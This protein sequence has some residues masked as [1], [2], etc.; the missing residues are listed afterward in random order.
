MNGVMI[1]NLWVRNFTLSVLPPLPGAPVFHSFGS[2][3]EMEVSFDVG[4]TW[5]SAASPSSDQMR[6]IYSGTSGGQNIYTTEM[7]TMSVSGGSLPMGVMIRESPT[8]ASNGQTTIK[9]IS[10]GYMIDSFFDIFIE[11]STDNGMTWAPAQGPTHIDLLVDPA[12][13]PAASNGPMMLP[14]IMCQDVSTA[15]VWQSYASG[16][17]LKNVKHKLWSM[18]TMPP[19]IGTSI[20]HSYS[21]IVDYEIS[22]D[23]GATFQTGRA[24]ATATETINGTR[25][26]LGAAT[27]ETEMTSLSISGGDLPIGIIIRESPTKASQGGITMTG[28]IGTYTVSSFFD[29]FTEISTDGGLSWQPAASGPGHLETQTIAHKSSYTSKLTP[30]P[31]AEF[32]SPSFKYPTGIVIKDFVA[33]YPSSSIMPPVAGSTITHSYSSEVKM[34]IST[35]SGITFTPYTSTANITMRLTGLMD[36]A[37]C[38]CFEIEIT[39]YN[40]ILPG[41]FIRESPTRASLGRLCHCIP[42]GPY[43]ISSFF[44]IFTEVSTDGGMTWASCLGG[45]GTVTQNPVVVDALT[46]TCPADMTVDATSSSGATVYYSPTVSGGYPP[47]TTICNPPSGSLLPVGATI[48]NCIAQDAI[49]NTAS[50]SFRVT[51]KPFVKRY[52]YDADKLTPANGAYICRSNSFVTFA[53][54][55]VIKNFW[56]RNFTVS[57]PPPVPGVP[58]TQNS[59]SQTSFDLS[60]D[61]GGT[62]TPVTLSSLN[63][64][65]MT[66]NTTIGG[67][68]RYDTEMLQMDL[69]GGS[70]PA[71]ILIRESPTKASQGES[72]IKP[73]TGGYMISS[74]FDIFI[75]VSTD[76]GISWM[77]STTPAQIDLIPDPLRTTA[78]ETSSQ[79]QPAPL[80]QN[81]STAAI[82][83]SYP[84]G[85]IIRNV[86][87]KLF[88][89]S[90]PGPVFGGGFTYSY[91]SQTDMQL[92]TDGGITWS[93]VRAPSQMTLMIYNVGEFK[94]NDFYDTEV[95]A[96]NISGGGLPV[97]VMIRESP[98]LISRGFTALQ[99]AG[100]GGGGGRYTISSFFD[101]FTEIST[102][103][104]LTW[105]QSGVG[106][107]HF[108]LLLPD[109]IWVYPDPVLRPLTGEYYNAGSLTATYPS[110]IQIANLI[111]SRYTSSVPVPAPGMTQ[112]ESYG[113]QEKMLISFDNG[114]TWSRVV[115][116]SSCTA[117]ITS[118]LDYGIARY[119]TTEMTALNISGGSLPAGVMIRESPTKASMGRTSVTTASGG[120]RISSFFDIFLEITFDGGMTWQPTTAGP[121]TVMLRPLS[122]N[123]CP[124]YDGL[125]VTDLKDFATLA[126]NWRWTEKPGDSA[127]RTDND[128][129]GVV[130]FK[131]LAI[132]VGKWLQNCP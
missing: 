101:I 10:G 106:P 83:Q 56:T 45:P 114:A 41:V 124:N 97:G 11:V 75:E 2:Q 9:A 60:I 50:C 70:L 35:D 13:I 27:Y 69:S 113:A 116:P 130:G 46:I 79:V 38:N 40:I 129:D 98:T 96:Y 33:K 80:S 47:V 30:T 14:P 95:L 120:Y 1:R 67:E 25:S 73:I 127:N 44:D 23:N 71:G 19:A 52:F 90:L 92:S 94:G 126:A 118:M 58:L 122:C 110:G 112:V 31:L 86:K 102:D 51:V 111:D 63:A 125:G 5:L 32:G 76:G 16:I 21:S 105:A 43:L 77:P 53:S 121:A 91:N 34:L 81:V 57:S 93:N 85:I 54:G 103:G 99:T 132:F 20:S 8:L 3:V 87:H 72:C 131:D 107:G 28:S 6:I 74:F 4:A 88:D 82:W 48:V 36:S 17:V 78:G 59:V 18:S 24:P 29:I 128:C 37:D 62:F 15:A 55:I 26:F 22:L 12:T 100:G 66:Y 117:Q 64:I 84:S 65:H 39:S 119:F 61:G 7:T 68:D 104:G 108:E 109:A 89:N 42:G 123:T 49:G 115:A